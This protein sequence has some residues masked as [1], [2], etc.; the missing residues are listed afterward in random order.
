MARSDLAILIPAFNEAQHIVQTLQQV[1]PYGTPVVVDDG[2]TDDTAALAQSVGAQLVSLTSNQGYDVALNEGFKA[3]DAMGFERL[4][5]FDADGQHPVAAI[6]AFESQL[7]KGVSLVLGQRQQTARWSE[8]LFAC[9]T[10]CRFGV[11]DPLCGMK[12]YQLSV[13]RQFGVFDQYGLIGT[14]LVL[15]ALKSG[16]S[17]IELPITVQARVGQSRFGTTLKGNLKILC[18]LSRAICYL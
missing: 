9:Y 18:A 11:S 3:I 12:G 16:V 14:E 17:M 1:I 8:S 7:S 13:Y 6:A 10:R 2:S 4:I 15:R 5:T